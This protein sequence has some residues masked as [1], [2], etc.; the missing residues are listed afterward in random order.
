MSS[1]ASGTRS[2]AGAQRIRTTGLR[3]CVPQNPALTSVWGWVWP[4]LIA[5]VGGFLRMLRLDHPRELVFDE[6]YYVK[7]AYSIAHHGVELKW[8]EDANPKFAAGDFSAL[9]DDPSYV[10][11]PPLGKWM[12]GAGQLIF[13]DGANPF[14]WR[15]AAALIG[16]ISIVVIARIAIRMFGSVWLGAAAALLLAADGQHFVHSR[17]GLLDIFVMFFVL[18][19][20]WLLLIDRDDARR[21]ILQRTGLNSDK[22]H[23]GPKPWFM[24]ASFGPSLGLRP[25]RLAG[26]IALGLACGVKWNGLYALAVF[27]IMI[28]LWDVANRRAAGI[29]RPWLAALGKDSVPAFMSLVPVAGIVYLLCW[30]GWILSP[31]GWDRGWVADN[32]GWWDFLP[33]WMVSL[34]HYHYTAYNFHVG[35]DKPHTY[36][37]NPWG[38]PVQWRPTSFY[39]RSYGLGEHGCTVEKCSA[40][41]LSVGNPVVWGLGTVALVVVLLAW[42]LR[43]DWRAGAILAGLAAV[44][45]PWFNYQHRTIFTFYTIVMVPFIVLALVY[46]LGIVWGSATGSASVRSLRARRLAIAGILAAAVLVFAFYYPIWTGTTIPYDSWRMRMLNPTWI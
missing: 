39:Y 13:G 16:T 44:W 34:A 5:A 2:N 31:K 20:F 6:T 19:A 41:I 36:M 42:V 38:W 4:M 18:I 10:V 17:T 46:A 32:S 12:L 28:V 21:R 8:A 29:R 1:L 11:H 26:G 23:T 40:A 35:L 37:S 7:D 9:T 33:D 27:G 15:F 45:L 43:R 22:Q 14:G 3:A 24:P 25:W 30:T